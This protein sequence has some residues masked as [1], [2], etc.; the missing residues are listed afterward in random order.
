MV[1]LHGETRLWAIEHLLE[2]QAHK[3]VGTISVDTDFLTFNSFQSIIVFAIS[4]VIV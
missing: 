3:N 2:L 1:E 4:S